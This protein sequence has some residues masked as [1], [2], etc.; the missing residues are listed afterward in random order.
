M[1]FKT[2]I[3]ISTYP[4]SQKGFSPFII[5]IAVIVLLGIGAG[6]FVFVSKKKG[7]DS[8]ER[9][10]KKAGQ[11][12]SFE[13][14][15]QP[16]EPIPA[17]RSEKTP[18]P[19]L[20]LQPSIKKLSLEGIQGYW[21]PQKHFFWDSYTGQLSEIPLVSENTITYIEFKNSDMCVGQFDK[22]GMPKPCITAFPFTLKDDMIVAEEKGFPPVNAK[23]QNN[24]QELVLE[25][26]ADKSVM[27]FR[28]AT[29]PL[30]QGITVS[31]LQQ[32]QIIDALTGIWKIEHAFSREIGGYK[33]S[34]ELAKNIGYQEFKANGTMCRLWTVD[35]VCNGYKPY[36]TITE[37]KIQTEVSYGGRYD[38]F[39][40]NITGGKLELIGDT[41]KGIYIKVS[42]IEG[43]IVNNNPLTSPII[44]TITVSAY[45]LQVGSEVI[46]TCKASDN[47]EVSWIDFTI[48]GPKVQHGW[49]YNPE[50][51][52]SKVLTA[53]YAY[54]LPDIGTYKISCRAFDDEE[55]ETL[56]DT[57]SV[58]AF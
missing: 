52:L 25:N 33:E 1:S 49:R 12:E 41:W 23:I 20:T 48:I 8:A 38:V 46:T 45:S 42:A 43:P 55:N 16:E 47:S 24:E 31:Q 18:H 2:N 51:K 4:I 37:H 28:K 58:T 30:Q 27:V 6:G 57:L 11:N 32:T 5:I 40:W 13:S 14:E 26:P 21:Q 54:T 7:M 53:S 39:I 17:P 10:E 9:G 35:P 3:P 36:T 34:K 56:S 19:P 44:E 50:A 15:L 29:V 22:S